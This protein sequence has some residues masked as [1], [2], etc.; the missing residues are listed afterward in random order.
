MLVT[1]CLTVILQVAF[2]P[3]PSFAFTVM[4]AVPAFFALIFP[5][6]E[7]VATDLLEEE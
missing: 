6:L 3:C 2:A 1:L 7:T 4:M 5:V